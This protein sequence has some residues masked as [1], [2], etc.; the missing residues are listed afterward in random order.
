MRVSSLL[1]STLL[2]FTTSILATPIRPG[3]DL[4]LKSYQDDIQQLST[5]QEVASR[6]DDPN[7]LNTIK[8]NA[9]EPD[10]NNSGMVFMRKKKTDANGQKMSLIKRLAVKAMGTLGVPDDMLQLIA[11]VPDPLLKKMVMQPLGKLKDSLD[12]LKAGKIPQVPGVDPKELMLA[13]LPNM[14]VSPAMLELVKAAPDSFTQQILN[15]PGDQLSS[16][17]AQLKQG[18]IPSIPGVSKKDLI[19]QFL[20]GLGINPVFIDVLKAA[21]EETFEAIANQPP[22]KL[23]S[24]LTGLKNGEVP[25]LGN[26]PGLTPTTPTDPAASSPAASAP[27]FSTIAGPSDPA[28][29]PAP[30]VPAASPALPIASAPAASSALPVASAPAASAALP[31]ASA[32][33]ASPA[34]PVASDPAAIPVTPVTPVTPVVPTDPAASPALPRPQ[35]PQLIQPP[36]Q[37]HQLQILLQQLQFKHLPRREYLFVTKA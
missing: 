35:R 2:V 9:V 34:L 33:A 32:P 17:I 19:L 28:A 36:L 1:V 27:A 15:M 37:R 24:L 18:K 13:V 20:P 26:L 4:Y 5:L 12:S 16:T 6:P 7:D 23:Q 10:D 31:V 22:E 30:S 8:L 14:G 29:T 21:P 25:E 3:Q 11:A